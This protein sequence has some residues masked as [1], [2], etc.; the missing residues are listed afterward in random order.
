MNSLEFVESRFAA[1]KIKLCWFLHQTEFGVEVLQLLA[2][3]KGVPTS[4]LVSRYAFQTITPIASVGNII[5]GLASPLCRAGRKCGRRKTQDRECVEQGS[6][7]ETFT[8]SPVAN[9]TKERIGKRYP[10][11]LYTM[12]IF[13]TPHD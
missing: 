9:V 12:V 5:P 10:R 6:H 13:Q 2:V 8:E 1:R 11:Y 4:R 3:G 7:G